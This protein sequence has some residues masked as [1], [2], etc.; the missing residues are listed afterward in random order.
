MIQRIAAKSHVSL[1][2]NSPCL[3]GSLFPIYLSRMVWGNLEA[4]STVEHKPFIL[5][6]RHRPCS[7]R[8]EEPSLGLPGICSFAS[9]NID[10]HRIMILLQALTA[11]LD[12]QQCFTFLYV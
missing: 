9:K 6:S 12:C 1:L 7:A 8:A 2:G 10:L 4:Q 5:A 3:P 11:K